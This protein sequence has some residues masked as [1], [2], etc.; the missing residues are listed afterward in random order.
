MYEKKENLVYVFFFIKR[1]LDFGVPMCGMVR[2]CVLGAVVDVCTMLEIYA[3]E[4][5]DGCARAL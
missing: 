1:G 3:C 5:S 4:L 2:V